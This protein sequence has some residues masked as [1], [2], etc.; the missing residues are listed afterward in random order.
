LTDSSVLAFS[1]RRCWAF[2]LCYSMCAEF[3]TWCIIILS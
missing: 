2:K 3:G 1:A